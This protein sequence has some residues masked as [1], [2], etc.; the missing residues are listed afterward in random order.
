[1]GIIS[2]NLDS[3]APRLLTPE[4]ID[5][6]RRDYFASYVG[7]R[8]DQVIREMQTGDVTIQDVRFRLLSKNPFHAAVTPLTVPGPESPT[9][10]V[11]GLGDSGPGTEGALS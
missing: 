8:K 9:P 2:D 1:M 11:Q 7:A 3:A 10:R 6:F 5:R 4:E